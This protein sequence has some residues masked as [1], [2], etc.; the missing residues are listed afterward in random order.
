MARFITDNAFDAQLD[1]IIDNGDTLHVCETAPTTYSD[2]VTA[3][4]TGTGKSLGSVSLSGID[5]AKAAGDTDGRKMTVAAQTGISIT[6]PG[7]ASQTA[8]HVAIVD[9]TGTELL[10]VTSMPA[11]AVTSGGT[12][13]LDAFSHTARDASAPA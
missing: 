2:A 10:F 1:H 6:T 8:D 5:Y 12:V 11:Q 7:G 4:G 13:D 9:T 3:L